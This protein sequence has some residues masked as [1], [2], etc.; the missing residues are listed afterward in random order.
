MSYV[1]DNWEDIS[2]DAYDAWMMSLQSELD[3]YEDIQDEQ[4]T[5][6]VECEIRSLA[7]LYAEQVKREFK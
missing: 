2:I 5:Y 7:N 3:H 4:G 6:E 1:L